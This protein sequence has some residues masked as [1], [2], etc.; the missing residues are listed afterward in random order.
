IDDAQVVCSQGFLALCEIVRR[1]ANMKL[2]EHRLA[3]LKE[4]ALSGREEPVFANHPSGRALVVV[5][6]RARREDALDG[7]R[8][9]SHGQ[10]NRGARAGAAGAAKTPGWHRPA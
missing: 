9:A 2:T 4:P 1:R 6:I 7:P 10:L 5:Q 3:G 8:P